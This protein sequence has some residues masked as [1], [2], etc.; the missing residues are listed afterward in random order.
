MSALG[1]LD[2][3]YFVCGSF[4]QAQIMLNDA[5][6]SLGSVGLKLNLA[7]VKWMANK[8]CHC[9]E[10]IALRIGRVLIP[11]VDHFVALGSMICIDGNE[12]PALRHRTGRAWGVF[13]KWSHILTC[14]APL[15]IRMKFW[16]RVVLPSMTWGVQTL[17]EPTLVN[18]Q[19]YCF[20]QKLMVRKMM[21][22]TRKCHGKH[23][24]DWLEWHKRSLSDAWVVA[25]R[26]KVG[27]AQVVRDL[28]EN[29]AGHISRLGVKSHCPH[30]LKYVLGWRPLL[31]WRVQQ[32]YNL[33]SFD[34]LVHPFGWGKPRRWENGLADDWWLELFQKEGYSR[35]L[36][37]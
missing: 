7:K 28:R 12:G 6:L 14:R 1:F 15:D 8:H 22:T 35:A 34:T 26:N 37:T 20:C 24:E 25:V 23:S 10:G 19:A 27:L 33:I 32:I 3:I 36:L 4:D 2:D 31:W 11:P 30:I 29:W 18:S 9:P 5:I 21:R 17:R 16:S 13:H